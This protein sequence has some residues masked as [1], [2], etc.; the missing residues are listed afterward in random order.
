M[1]RK[2][3][4]DVNAFLM[5]GDKVP[6]ASFLK[7]GDTHEGEILDLKKS[8]QTDIKTGKPQFW[9]NGDPKIQIVVTIQTEENDD[10]IE[11]DDGRRR[12]YLKFNLLKAVREA[13]N[14]AEA[15]NGLEIGGWLSVT[16]V[17]Q[18]K[19]AS[20]AVSGT[21]HYEATYEEPD[22][23]AAANAYLEGGDG[24]EEPEPEPEPAKPAARRRAPAKA[25]E[26]EPE[27]PPRRSR[28]TAAAAS[29]APARGRSGG[30][31]KF[32]DDENEEPF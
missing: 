9:D 6:S 31:S 13:I 14:E 5:G 16:F 27:T 4:D 24:E 7:I 10:E 8:Q 28:R 20:R 11:D 3:L 17:K 15:E 25:A 19:P 30:R 18:D 1:S 12:L 26:P 21:K 22:P 2:N 29:A 32:V 23:A